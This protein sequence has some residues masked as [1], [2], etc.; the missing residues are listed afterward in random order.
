MVG[1][2][3]Q[4]IEYV[5]ER[6]KS[7]FINLTVFSL[8][9]FFGMTSPGEGTGSGRAALSFSN[10]LSAALQRIDIAHRQFLA[11]WVPRLQGDWKS[12]HRCC[13]Y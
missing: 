10:L 12:I 9:T 8:L 13:F 11:F 1:H 6:G 2:I 7:T 5:L 3:I 4:N